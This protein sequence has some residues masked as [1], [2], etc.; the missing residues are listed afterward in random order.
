MLGRPITH[1]LSPV[2]HN[3]A[4]R[5]LGLAWEYTAIDCGTDELAAVLDQRADWQGFSLTMPLKRVGL[6]LA[7]EVSPRAAVVGAANT[8][9]PAAGGWRA[10]NTDVAGVVAAVAESGQTPSSVTVLGAGGTAQAVVAAVAELG[11]FDCAVLVRDV[12]RT[13]ELAETAERAGV[14]LAIGSLAVDA[15]PLGADLVVNT[16]PAGAADPLANASWRRGQCLLDAVYSP[17][18]TALA[19]GALAAG[20]LVVSGALM[21][22]HQAVEQVELMTGQTAPAASMRAALRDAIPAADL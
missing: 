16:L 17:W 8:L 5:A 1:S 2:L 19:A 14:T 18:P 12:A 22:L 4:Y 9:L 13:A 6:E 3:A 20:T 10:D 11:L 21:L 15:P 7:V